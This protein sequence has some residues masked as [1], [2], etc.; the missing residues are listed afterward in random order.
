MS[1]RRIGICGY[2]YRQRSTSVILEI[3]TTLLK[4]M[5]SAREVRTILFFL[6]THSL[7]FHRDFPDPIAVIRKLLFEVQKRV[8]YRHA[9]DILYF[10]KSELRRLRAAVFDIFPKCVV[11]APFFASLFVNIAVS[12]SEHPRDIRIEVELN[13]W[14]RKIRLRHVDTVAE[15]NAKIRRER[16]CCFFVPTSC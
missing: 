13:N 15:R 8:V 3:I 16:I 7:F 10:I 1:I 4:L 2:K 9:G 11:F 6:K 14:K 12:L 5:L